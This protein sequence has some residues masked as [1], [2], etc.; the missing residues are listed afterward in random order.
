MELLDTYKKL[1]KKNIKNYILSQSLDESFSKYIKNKTILNGR[2]SIT[3]IIG[4]GAFGVVTKAF[5]IL[6]KKDVAIKVMKN[7]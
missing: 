6:D 4:R 1:K 2:Y 3:Q 7:T 5:D